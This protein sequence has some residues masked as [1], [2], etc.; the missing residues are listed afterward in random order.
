MVF[1]APTLYPPIATARPGVMELSESIDGV[2][3]NGYAEWYVDQTNKLTITDITRKETSRQFKK[4]KN[5]NLHFGLSVDTYWARFR[6]VNPTDEEISWILETEEAGMDSVSVF[7]LT[8]DGGFVMKTTGDMYRFFADR[9]ID[10]RK[11]SFKM[12]TPPKTELMVYMRFQGIP[13]AVMNLT[14]TVY[15]PASYRDALTL[16]YLLLGLF[17]GV[18][19]VMFFY[20][21]MIGISLHEKA[22]LYYCG[23]V[24][25]L[26]FL[27]INLNGLGF[28]YIWPESL[29]LHNHVI[30]WSVGLAFMMACVF[31]RE[32]LKTKE[33]LPRIDKILLFGIF[34]GFI[35]TVLFFMAELQIA[36]RYAYF[37]TLLLPTFLI[38]GIISLANGYRAAR[39]YVFSWAMFV[40]GGLIYSLKD[41]GIFPYNEFSKWSAQVG[42]GL[43]ATLISFAL[44][45]RI[46]ILA[47]EKNNAELKIKQTLLLGK[48]ELEEKVALRTVELV[49]E[50]EIAQEATR[51][52]DKFVS[53]VSND[54][55]G[56]LEKMRGFVTPKTDDG[57]N[58]AQEDIIQAPGQIM[59]ITDDLLTRIDEI[60]DVG[61]L[62]RGA[63]A[64]VKT[65]ISVSDIISRGVESLLHSA[66]QK[67]ITI[68]N[69]LPPDMIIAADR[70]MLGKVIY[71]LLSNAIK[72]SESGDKVTI[73]SPETG[74]IAIQ[75][76]GIGMDREFAGKLFTHDIR[77][78]KTGTAGEKGTGHGLPYCH[79]IMKAHG[80]DV[81]VETTKG[82]GSIFYLELPDQKPV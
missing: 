53:L 62:K 42:T 70:G 28:Q 81:R 41:L 11:M 80:G 57:D 51:L 16:E 48:L 24:F 3:I 54:L 39:F 75:D 60:L 23:Y 19:L 36:V 9:D 15:T 37:L 40:I 49:E 22:Y 82:K 10:S 52:K 56:P 12:S 43:E 18:I 2:L 69:E 44:A 79:D 32:F 17:Y 7:A 5:K 27:W 6:V 64:P 21:L 74:V 30:A 14:S 66:E 63:I 13:I 68:S 45:D 76:T 1:L 65:G 61:R 38:A 67:G 29:E 77:T 25:T 72:F 46:K 33:L 58:R 31:S 73:L 55:R 8:P 47:T 71:N 78:T 26:S 34:L 4:A 50:K 35:S 20:N 59:D